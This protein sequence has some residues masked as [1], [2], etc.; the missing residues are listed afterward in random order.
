MGAWKLAFRSLY[1]RMFGDLKI[2][3]GRIADGICKQHRSQKPRHSER[4]SRLATARRSH[5]PL[6]L[7]VYEEGLPLRATLGNKHDAC[8]AWCSLTRATHEVRVD[9]WRHVK[10]LCEDLPVQSDAM[11]IG[12]K[13]Y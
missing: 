1:G 3:P 2:F 12:L 9:T 13:A 11:E 10:L 4:R 7:Q 6:A 5:E 8:C